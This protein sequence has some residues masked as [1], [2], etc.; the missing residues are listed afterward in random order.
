M[1]IDCD[2]R[3]P[4]GRSH[5]SSSASK[6]SPIYHSLALFALLLHLSRINDR[7]IG[8]NHRVFRIPALDR[9]CKS[10]NE[11]FPAAIDEDRVA[12]ISCDR[13]FSSPPPRPPRELETTDVSKIGEQYTTGGERKETRSNYV[14]GL[15]RP[16][17]KCRTRTGYWSRKFLWRKTGPVNN[18][19]FH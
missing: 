13:F 1:T 19:Y 7:E 14:F 17:V 11:I 6:I 2:C 16:A 18:G 9:R 5:G 15:I 8:F 4:N 10:I 12:Y 3:V